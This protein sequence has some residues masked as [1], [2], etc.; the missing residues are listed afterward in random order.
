MAHSVRSRIVTKS[1][2]T[3]CNGDGQSTCVTPVTPT[4]VCE[5]LVGARDV[6]DA[7]VLYFIS[8]LPNV[9]QVSFQGANPIA[10]FQA[11]HDRQR[12]DKLLLVTFIHDYGHTSR[13]RQTYSILQKGDII[14]VVK[15]RLELGTPILRIMLPLQIIE[16]GSS[17]QQRW[18]KEQVALVE[19]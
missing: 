17:K 12:T 4:I 14:K 3:A 1:F 19:C 13:T 2:H 9:R 10:I 5:Y 16:R 7:M 18:F 15:N 11:L 6:P 8:L